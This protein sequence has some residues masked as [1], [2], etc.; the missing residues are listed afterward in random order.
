M[1]NKTEIF[2]N[3]KVKKRKQEIDWKLKR[4]KK[5][6]SENQT[7]IINLIIWR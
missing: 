1:K 2:E 7:T 3:R 4:W 5:K 6:I